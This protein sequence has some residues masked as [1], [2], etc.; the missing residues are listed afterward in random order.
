[1][2]LFSGKNTAKYATR[3]HT[4]KTEWKAELEVMNL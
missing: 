3:E 1:M 2:A 4:K